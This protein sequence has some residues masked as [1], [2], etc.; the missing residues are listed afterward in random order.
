MGKVKEFFADA[1]AFPRTYTH[2]GHNGIDTRTY[3]AGRAMQGLLAHTGSFGETGELTAL[4]ARSVDAAD[5][6]IA[7]LA[8][9]SS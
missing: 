1:P 8:K 7:A 5:A 3:L 4:A 2:D 6:L 9:A